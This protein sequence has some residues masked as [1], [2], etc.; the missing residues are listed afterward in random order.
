M[1]RGLLVGAVVAVGSMSLAKDEWPQF[2]GPD[3]SGHAKAVGLPLT[4][5]ETQNVKWKSAIPGKGHS[6]PVISDNQIWV[7]TAVENALSP[8][9]KKA[10][11][12]K[13]KNPQGL[14][15]AGTVSLRAICIDRDSGK[16]LHDVEVLKIDEPQPIHSL[17]S[18]ASPTSVLENDRLYCHFGAYGTFA[19]DT[20]SGKVVWQNTEHKIDHQN[21]PGS[22]PASWGKLLFINFDGTDKQYVAAIDKATGKTEWMTK[23]SGKMDAQP[24]LQKA[25]CTPVLVEGSTGM[26]VVSPGANWV[27]GYDAAT[28][29]EIW[30]AGYGQLGFSTVPRPI[31]GHGMVYVATSYMQSRLV[32]VKLGGS[33]DITE[34]HVAWK[35]DVAVPQKPS[36]LLVGDELY[37]VNDKG[38]VVCLDAKTK[39]ERWRERVPGQYS[40]S[41]VYVDGRIYLC[42]QEGKTTVIAPSRQYKELASNQLDGGFMASPAV[43]GKALFLRTDTHLY[44]IEE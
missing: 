10:R 22:S 9:E 43:A 18:Y 2:R 37:F 36:M 13:I 1:V 27:Y 31:I 11:L 35:H 5:S 40:A 30:K 7:T 39:E 38:I 34:S 44:R 16:L 4:W 3:G 24:D 17:N 15:L 32:A 20:Q 33:G 25:Y 6:S 23:R 19:I 26:Q 21:G 12:S 41:P 29:R 28:G 42:S 14:E 8:E